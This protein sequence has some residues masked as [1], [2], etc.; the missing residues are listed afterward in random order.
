MIIHGQNRY[1]LGGAERKRGHAQKLRE[2][3]SVRPVVK[4]APLGRRCRLGVRRSAFY[5]VHPLYSSE[6][7]FCC[8]PRPAYIPTYRHLSGTLN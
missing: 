8:A 2:S 1:P 7:F 5:E 3:F 4:T 6:T